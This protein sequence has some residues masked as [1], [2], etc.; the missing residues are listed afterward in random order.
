MI[1]EISEG[2][3]VEMLG[4][5]IEEVTIEKQ[6]DMTK[7]TVDMVLNLMIEQTVDMINDE[8]KRSMMIDDLMI[9]ER[10]ID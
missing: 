9:D 2:M 7:K 4:V 5:M 10:M 6:I 8:K 1:E 3:T